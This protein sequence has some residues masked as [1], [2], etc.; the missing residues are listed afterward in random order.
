MEGLIARPLRRDKLRPVRLWWGGPGGGLGSLAPGAT[1]EVAGA[2]EA[3]GVAD[4]GRGG[5]VVGSLPGGGVACW[6]A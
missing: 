1:W 5:L 2:E 6:W 3:D 4:G